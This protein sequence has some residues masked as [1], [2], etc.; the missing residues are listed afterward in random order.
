MTKTKMLTLISSP[1]RA[2]ERGE[3][4][5]GLVLGAP[6]SADTVVLGQLHLDTYEPGSASDT[7]PT[8]PIAAEELTTSRP[9]LSSCSTPRFPQYTDGSAVHR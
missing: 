7:V 1:D 8:R 5:L 3:L 2:T 9:M 6:S 4:T